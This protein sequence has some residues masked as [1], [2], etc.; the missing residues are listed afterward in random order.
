MRI[1]QNPAKFVKNVSRPERITAAV[2]NCI[3]FLS[4]FY[5]E[6]LDVL[7]ASLLS[8]RNAPGL[9]FDLMVFDNGSCQQA[10]DFLVAEKEAGHVQYL[11]LS[12]KNVGKGGAWNVILAGAP[13]DI[14]AYSDSD[15]LFS[16]GWLSR[17]VEILEGFPNVGMV[18]ARPFRTPPEFFEGTLRWAREQAQLEEGQFIPWETF[19]EF[20]LSLG[21]TEDEN[22]KVYAE[23]RDWRIKYQGVSAFAGASHW[24]FT[25]YKSRLRQFLPFDMDKP[26]GQVRELDR[27][28][29]DAGLLRLMVSDPLAMNMSN[30]LGYL[31]GELKNGTTLGGTSAGRRLLNFGPLKRML[32]AAYN[33]I[34]RWYY[35]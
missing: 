31:R 10:R 30:T 6:A 18:T 27:R 34:F 15:V 35:S 7:Q 8:L 33:T 19:L 11:I 21:Q 32:L 29:N 2:L 28:M 26:M 5:A 24:Q 1:G 25:A 12:E 22:R 16:P 9:P 17:S 14:V 4:G 13:G 20:N 23:T 3:P